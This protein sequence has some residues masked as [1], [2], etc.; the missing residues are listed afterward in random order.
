MRSCKLFFLSTTVF[1][2][3]ESIS[4]PRRL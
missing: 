4:H 3:A 1:L 2:S